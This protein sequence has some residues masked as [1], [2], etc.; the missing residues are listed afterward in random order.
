M[1]TQ[2]T[3]LALL[4]KKG[5]RITSLRREILRTFRK[6][7]ASLTVA[8]L[9]A[10]VRKRIRSAGLQ[11]VYRNLADFTRIGIT[12]EVFL[13]G[14]KATYALCHGVSIHHHHVVCRRCGHVVEMTA[15]E[16]GAVTRNLERSMKKIER[17]TGFHID[18]H[19]L[20]LE[21]LCHACRTT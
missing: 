2:D 21:G 10:I 15:C 7:C 11:S 19:S 18:R 13:G 6:K 20:Q 16:L 17:K 4:R 8:R 5:F 3:Y 14:R 12:E 9:W 1:K